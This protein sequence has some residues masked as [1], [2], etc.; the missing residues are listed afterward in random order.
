MLSL[1]ENPESQV[2]L[3]KFCQELS[4]IPSGH[5]YDTPL[6]DDRPILPLTTNSRTF[7]NVFFEY[8][9]KFAYIIEAEGYK[10]HSPGSVL[11]IGMHG[12]ARTD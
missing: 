6:Y 3:P 8:N 7:F 1:Q 5:Y 9:S 2:Y 10:G 11:P 4:V 12:D